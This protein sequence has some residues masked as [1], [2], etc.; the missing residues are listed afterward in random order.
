MTKPIICA[1]AL[2]AIN[3]KNGFVTSCPQQSDQLHVYKDT[4]VLKPSEIINSE[5]FKKHRK[6]LMSGTW[7]K[8]CHLCKEAEEIG[9]PSMRQDYLVTDQDL[10]LY[11]NESGE[12]NFK[13]IKH[14]EL[15]F[16][17][18]CNMA[19]LHCSDV[20]SSGWVSKLKNY[21]PDEED[22]KHKLLQLTKTFHKLTPDED[23]TISISIN[24]MEIIIDDLIENFPN[25]KKVD[26]AGGEVLYQ[27]Q[28]FPCLRKLSKHPNV[29]NMKVSFHT[30]F[31][32]KF[33][34]E[35]LSEVL[36]PFGKVSIQMSLDAGKNIYPY[37]RTGDWEVLKSNV[38]RFRKV[39][40][41]CELNI[42]CTTSVYQIMDIEDVFKS[43]MELDVNFIDSAIVYTPRYIN[44]ALMVMHFKDEVYQDI[45]KTYK[46]LSDELKYRLE[47]L[48]SYE[49]RKSWVPNRKEFTDIR[50]AFKALEEIE[51]YVF[52]H[53]CK[54]EE[55]D[56]L[57]VYIR[58]TDSIWK[59]NFNDFIKKYEF[60]DN[61]L[62]RSINV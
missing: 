19:C 45:Q 56:A 40:N 42:K 17:N 61:Q 7:S 12:T 60:K 15:R 2:G 48:S 50:T 30:N 35:E 37:F 47:N 22:K 6:E 41:K 32:A 16:S 21:V 29:K 49:H 3:Y 1:Y 53:Q 36:Q 43:F 27:K 5:N 58:K 38:E 54:K 20:Y 52:N 4:K 26:F 9:S 10:E 28:F 31:N 23:L 62:V 33:K 18:S 13:L 14:V 34:P 25:L 59:R 51:H 39:D 8:G 55:W 57:L 44:P 11:N 46:M 24:E